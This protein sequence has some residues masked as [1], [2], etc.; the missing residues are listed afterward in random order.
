MSSSPRVGD[1]TTSVVGQTDIW[2]KRPT[3]SGSLPTLN[4]SVVFQLSPS[5][6]WIRDDPGRSEGKDRKYLPVTTRD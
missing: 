5:P 6:V 2:V 4:G 1:P 3:L